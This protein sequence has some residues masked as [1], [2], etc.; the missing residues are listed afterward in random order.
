ME[1]FITSETNP[2]IVKKVGYIDVRN[3]EELQKNAEIISEETGVPFGQVYAYR[4]INQWIKIENEW[5]YYKS[6][7]DFYLANEL[8]GEVI[9]QYFG[10]DTVHYQIIRLLGDNWETYKIMSKNICDPNAIFKKPSDFRNFRYYY[11][12][13]VL[14]NLHSL[15]KSESEHQLLL[16]DIKKLFIRDFYVSQDD[17]NEYNFMFRID[18]DGI[19]LAPLFDYEY[20]FNPTTPKKYFNPCGVT[21]LKK[22]CNSMGSIDMDDEKTICRL[23]DDEEFQRLLYLIMGAKMKLLIQYVEDNHR[24]I[25]PSDYKEI[26]LNHDKEMKKII[27]ESNVLR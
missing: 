8:L 20:S 5:Y 16:S 25:I 1:R 18:E 24:I 15:C 17:R 26:Y 6:N 27:R 2:R 13:E 7:H 4:Y 22:Y 19:R 9:S 11:R 23:R 21:T 12:L 14:D 3:N 10:L